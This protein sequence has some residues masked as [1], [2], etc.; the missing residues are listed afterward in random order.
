VHV[1]VA[2]PTPSHS[3]YPGALLSHEVELWMAASEDKNRKFSPVTVIAWQT[4]SQGTILTPRVQEFSRE[5]GCHQYPAYLTLL[6]GVVKDCEWG[7]SARLHVPDETIAKLFADGW[8]AGW[9]ALGFKSKPKAYRAEARQLWEAMQS[10]QVTIEADAMPSAATGLILDHLAAMADRKRR[11]VPE[12]T[13]DDLR[14][15]ETPWIK[16]DPDA[17]M[18]RAMERDRSGE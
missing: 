9:A 10:R 13:L 8:L 18:R 12:P 16:E 11:G 15:N 6:I 5:N 2:G 14:L 7:A 1:G 4:R 17:A 3:H